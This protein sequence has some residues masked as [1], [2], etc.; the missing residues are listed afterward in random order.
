MRQELNQWSHN[1]TMR[2]KNTKVASVTHNN[3]A[4][5]LHHYQRIYNSRK[6]TSGSSARFNS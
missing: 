2:L 1:Q 6:Y 4:L 3:N 5:L